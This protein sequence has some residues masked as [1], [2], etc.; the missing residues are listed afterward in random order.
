M[1]GQWSAAAH[2]FKGDSMDLKEIEKHEPIPSH[3]GKEYGIVRLKNWWWLITEVK[4]LRVTVAARDATLHSV[5]EMLKVSNDEVK[6]L[7]ERGP[8]NPRAHEN[9]FKGE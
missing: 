8:E 6:R 1:A 9:I 4:E 3:L 5:S 2:A 7:R